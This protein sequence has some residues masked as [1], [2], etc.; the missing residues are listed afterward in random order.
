[1]G[2]ENKISGPVICADCHKNEYKSVKPI[3]YPAVEFDFSY[4]D[5]HVKKLNEKLGKDDCG[6]CHHTYKLEEQDE[7]LALVYEEGTEESCYYCHEVGANRGPEY[8]AITRV[9]EKEGLTIRKASHQQC[10]NCHL[11]Y[12]KEFAES[13]NKEEKAGPTECMKCHTGKYKTVAELE[14][15]PKPD[16]DQ[17]DRSFINIDDAKL[18]GVP[19]D[20]KY[21]E[22]NAKTC[23]S[24][25]HESLKPCKECH[26]LVGKPEG[27]GINV[28]AAYHDPFSEHS[29]E[30]CHNEIKKEKECAGCHS[31]IPIVALDSI[32]PKKESCATCHNGKKEGSFSR[33]ALSTAGLNTDV[34]K[35]EVE[36]DILKREFEPSK[37]PHL[38]II[39]QL[40]DISN[41]SKL[42]NYF[43]TD[44]QVL[45]EGCH[46]RSTEA[47]EVKKDTPPYCR[48]CHTTIY[49]PKDLNK[50]TLLS[51]YHRQ[52]L[53]CHD[54]MELEK[55]RKCSDCHEPKAGP[56]RITDLEEQNKDVVRANEENIINVWRP[57]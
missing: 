31:N 40:V 14:K 9:A 30:G 22:D 1:M 54:E 50:T 2:R 11:K 43:H 45:C 5:T 23:R 32:G 55:G 53:G 24:C 38:E 35:K 21:H 41:D 37:F 44:M 39:K 27:N 18:K 12:E 8:A 19:F 47:A 48:N 28:A 56:V 33:P 7:E 57:K 15:V 16:R 17:K 49:N 13:Q 3:M 29:C 42:A 6:Q 36:I 52:C 25:H 26:D 46:H 20:H 10:L 51:A 34:V 4:H